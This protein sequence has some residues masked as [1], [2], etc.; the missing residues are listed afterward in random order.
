MDARAI[1]GL[2]CEKQFPTAIPHDDH[3]CILAK[4]THRERSLA[5][6]LSLRMAMELE[7]LAL[8][9]PNLAEHYARL[10]AAL[11]ALKAQRAVEDR[12]IGA[13]LKTPPIEKRAA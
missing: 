1:W 6:E 10:T 12:E 4:L 5:M 7:Q 11:P 2:L 13:A 9:D 8:S 3:Y